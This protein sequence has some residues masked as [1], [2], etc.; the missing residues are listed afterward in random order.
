M[1]FARP[2]AARKSI[3]ANELYRADAPES[4]SQGPMEINRVGFGPGGIRDIRRV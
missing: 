3:P 4:S 2:G 1:G